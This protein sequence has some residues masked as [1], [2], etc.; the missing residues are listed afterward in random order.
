MC[1]LIWHEKYLNLSLEVANSLHTKD[2]FIEELVIGLFSNAYFLPSEK[3]Y[4]VP[5]LL[6]NIELVRTEILKKPTF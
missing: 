1:V 2:F 4:N 6:K 5:N 3:N